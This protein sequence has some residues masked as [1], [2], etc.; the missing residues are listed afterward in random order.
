MQQ[1]KKNEFY[2]QRQDF[3]KTTSYFSKLITLQKTKNNG[4]YVNM[5][6]F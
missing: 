5:P 2:C 1:C 3:E 4:C 6:N